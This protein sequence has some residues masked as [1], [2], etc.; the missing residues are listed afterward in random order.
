MF[1]ARLSIC[2]SL[3]LGV[4]LLS[5]NAFAADTL[6]VKN[7]DGTF[8][9]GAAMSWKATDKGVVF[10][11]ADGEDGAAW[12]EAL[13]DRLAGVTV[14]FAN[15]VITV[16]GTAKDALLEQ[17]STFMLSGGVDPLAELAGLGG[18]VTAMDTPEGGGSIRASKPMAIAFPKEAMKEPKADERFEA[19]VLKVKQG[20]FP[21]VVLKLKMRKAGRENP[22]HKKLYYGKIIDAKVQ[23]F[24]ENDKVDLTRKCNQRNLVSWFLKK[25]DKVQVHPVLVDET[26]F[27]VDWIARD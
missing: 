23:Y 5:S 13:K 1:Q 17:L 16:K 10:K 8:G 21:N 24:P 7:A 3:V 11:V 18:G 9:P 20:T 19:E 15:N 27:K 2:F 12:A 25:G 6:V 26:N 14:S 22:L 4:L